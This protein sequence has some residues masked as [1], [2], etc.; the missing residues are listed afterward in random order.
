MVEKTENLSKQLNEMGQRLEAINVQIEGLHNLVHKIG[1]AS[2]QILDVDKALNAKFDNLAETFTFL[3]LDIQGITIDE[4][5]IEEIRK[6]AQEKHVPL[7]EMVKE[8][9]KEHI[10]S[11]KKLYA[12]K[13]A[14]G[15]MFPT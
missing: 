1:N 7:S 10:V 6:L 2:N 4:S 11:I 5:E 9:E 8:L 15:E 13:K 12:I 14:L 3:I